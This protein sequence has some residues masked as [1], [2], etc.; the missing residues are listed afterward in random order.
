M[1]CWFFPRAFS[2]RLGASDMNLPAG[3]VRR[4]VTVLMVT[5]VAILLGGVSFLRLPI[6]LMPD[7][8]YPTI[9][10]RAEYPGVAA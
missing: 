9:S 1:H 2:E 10:V 3:S 7:I 4:P 5:L 8:E 6:D